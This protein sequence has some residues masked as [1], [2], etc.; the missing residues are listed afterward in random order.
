MADHPCT[1][2]TPEASFP[3]SDAEAYVRFGL[4]HRRL[5]RQYADALDNYAQ[6]AGLCLDWTAR[7]LLD[8]WMTPIPGVLYELTEETQ[9]RDGD[10]RYALTAD[11]VNALAEWLAAGDPLAPISDLTPGPRAALIVL[12][13]QGT[14]PVAES[15]LRSSKA[16]AAAFDEMLPTDGPSEVLCTANRPALTRLEIQGVLAQLVRQDIATRLG[17]PDGTMGG[18]QVGQYLRRAVESGLATA[19]TPQR[20]RGSDSI[21]ILQPDAWVATRRFFR[22]NHGVDPD[23]AAFAARLARRSSVRTPLPLHARSATAIEERAA[24]VSVHEVL[25]SIMLHHPGAIWGTATLVSMPLRVHPKGHPREGHPTAYSILDQFGQPTRSAEP[26]HRTPDGAV[27]FYPETYPDVLVEF[28]GDGKK[29]RIA[30][31]IEAALWQSSEAQ[32]HL[33]LIFATTTRSETSV[34]RTV[35]EFISSRQPSLHRAD[36]PEASLQVRVNRIDRLRQ[37]CP[38]H[39]R[40]DREWWVR[41]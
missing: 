36:W 26:T 30:E 13:G 10:P 6:R 4:G 27:W 2:L 20:V 14:G 41:P 15:T 32:N 5:T 9:D 1:H 11:G 7:Q 28:E 23:A 19:T 39:G 8:G 37:Q 29:A 3:T 18:R 31:H 22:S 12:A 24:L 17:I 38:I 21:G 34:E 33:T 35:G 25:G 16:R 40:A